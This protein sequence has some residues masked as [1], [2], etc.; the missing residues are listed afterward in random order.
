[1][2]IFLNSLP[3]SGTNMVQKCLELAS[4]SYSGNSLAAS[5]CFGKFGLIKK[6][7]R[8]PKLG[9]VPVVIG[10][11]IP[12]GVSPKWIREYLHKSEGYVSGHA[13]FSEHCYSILNS[14]G[15][16]TIQVVR[17]PC[18]VLAS[19]ANYIA[20][21]GYYWDEVHIQ[22]AKMDFSERVRFLLNGGSVNTDDF[23]VYYK[24]F[25]DVLL[26]VE[27]WIEAENVLTVRFE[28][29]VGEKG[30]GCNDAQRK[31]IAKVLNHIGMDF[32]NEDLDRL[33]AEL[34]GGTHTFRSGQIDSWKKEIDEE[35]AELISITLKDCAIIKKLG[36]SEIL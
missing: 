23:T 32:Q 28:D 13:A 7:M 29:M 25:S 19:W 15:Y 9:Q 34:Y 27:G 30:G 10:L 11:E 8:Q 36:Y 20:E 22:L 1:M 14:E 24:S 6:M 26:Q 31:S 5:S 18:A 2:K 12:V 3:K 16:K 33:Q 21:P 4:I 35:L 17:H